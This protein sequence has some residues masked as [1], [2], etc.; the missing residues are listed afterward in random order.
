MRISR[1]CSLVHGNR[2]IEIGRGKGGERS[3]RRMRIRIK[4]A[5]K[6]NVCRRCIVSRKSENAELS[7]KAESVPPPP[8]LHRP[9]VDP[10]HPNVTSHIQR[11][12]RH[13]RQT[14]KT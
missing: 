9:W 4:R 1:L 12:H 14:S 6:V 3:T 10:L 13:G 11:P 2:G 8:Q 7:N 5:E